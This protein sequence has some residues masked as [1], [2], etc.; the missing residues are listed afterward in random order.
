MAYEGGIDLV[1]G[2]RP[3]N[4]QNFSIANA[5]D[6]Y[7]DDGTENGESLK[8]ILINIINRLNALETQNNIT[9]SQEG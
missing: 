1:A 8:N 9:P 7:Y 6:I 4:N 2:L 5:K 3:K